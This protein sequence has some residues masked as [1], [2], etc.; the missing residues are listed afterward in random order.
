[1]VKQI[2]FTGGKDGRHAWNID[3]QVGLNSPNK[4]ADVEL[5]QLAY[6]MMSRNGKVN[7]AQD[8]RNLISQLKVGDR[9]AGT[10]DDLLVR[11]I[12]NHQRVRGGTQDGKVSPITT[13]T[14]IYLEKG[15]HV[16]MLVIL[17][18]NLL[19]GMPFLYPR[20]DQHPD[21][22]INLKKAILETYGLPGFLALE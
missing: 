18:N 17:N 20:V 9:C 13:T 7:L 22:P 11:I 4:A 8:Q 1:M 21:C 10:P 14:G 6:V 3:A 2:I 5:V 12:R 19:D 16:Y 15:S